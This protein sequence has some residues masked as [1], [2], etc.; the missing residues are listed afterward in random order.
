MG[1]LLGRDSGLVSSHAQEGGRIPV[2]LR[3]AAANRSLVAAGVVA[4]A[5]LV[6]YSRTLMPDVGFWDTGEFQAI[7]PVLGIAH[8]TGYPAYTMLAWVASVVLQPFGNEALRANLLSAIVAAIGGALV[9]A[10]VARVTGRLI[11]GIAAGVALAVSAEAW[12]IGLR[13]DPHALHLML[14]AAVLLFLVVW[15]ER[16]KAGEPAERWLFAAAGTVGISLA[17]H[18]LTLLLAPGIAIFVLAVEPGILRRWR[19]IVACAA[20]LAFTTLALYAYLPIRSAMNPVL[21]YANPQTW[22]GFRYL[23]FAEQF[24]GTFRALPDLFAALRTIGDE[25]FAQLGVF[26]P[27]AIIGLFAAARRRPALLLLLA[28]WFG[29]NWLFALGYVNA[30]IGRYYLVPLLA[31]S[32][33]GGL[34]AG[35]VVDLLGS[36]WSR[37]VADDRAARVSRYALATTVAVALIGPSLLSVPDR[38]DRVD[39]SGDFVARRW[40]TS[41]TQRLPEDAVVVSWWSYSTTLWYGQYV[42]HLR[43]DITVIDDSTIVQQNLG[44]VAAVIDS[45]LGQRPIFLIRLSFDLPQFE[46]RYVLTPLPGVVGGPVYRVDGMRASGAALAHL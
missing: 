31:A 27:L 7:G 14:A 26:A 4:A 12:S 11:V 17:N 15:Q 38:F 39:A 18:G 36:L 8:P 32:V 20:G 22:E 40:L 37:L 42:D 44:S 13:A 33:L 28:A 46:Q 3:R 19:L 5:A 9:A 1:H 29:V 45:Y 16:V 43:P 10:I 2:A 24:R 6:L 35:A 34:G 21:D 25:T 23:V 41:V 30:D